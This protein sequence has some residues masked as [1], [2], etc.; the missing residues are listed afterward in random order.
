MQSINKGKRG[1][2]VIWLEHML[3]IVRCKRIYMK[4]IKKKRTCRMNLIVSDLKPLTT[5][6]RPKQKQKGRKEKRKA[7]SLFL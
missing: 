7:S 6:R 4:W 2:K 5:F 1:W 3:Y